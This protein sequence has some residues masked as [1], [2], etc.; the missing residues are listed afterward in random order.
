MGV[1]DDERK[2]L[3]AENQA[4]RAEM[5][6]FKAE[7][8]AAI[9][10]AQERSTLAQERSI[11]A[12]QRSNLAQ[13]R[14]RIAEEKAIIEIEWLKVKLATQADESARLRAQG[15]KLPFP[16]FSF[17]PQL[18]KIG[19]LVDALQKAKDKKRSKNSIWRANKRARMQYE[20]NP[21]GN[22]VD[23]EMEGN[24]E[25]VEDDMVEYLR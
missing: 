2:A 10:L 4:L 1:A 19:K 7:S 8:K 5:D 3:R 13:E 14:G 21:Q 17:I 11:L 23:I 9:A 22:D 16:F 18:A 6:A 15:K 25:D 24:G 20:A 12:E